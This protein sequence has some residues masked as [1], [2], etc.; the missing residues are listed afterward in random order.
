MND[1]ECGMRA[2]AGACGIGK[3]AIFD[4]NTN[5]CACT[6]MI[7]AGTRFPV[8]SSILILTGIW[9]IYYFFRKKNE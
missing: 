6:N 2:F 3:V 4:N 9:L 5:L 8:A 7:H 1:M